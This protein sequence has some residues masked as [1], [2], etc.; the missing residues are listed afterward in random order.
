MFGSAGGGVDVQEENQQDL[1]TTYQQPR[2]V[3]TGMGVVSPIGIG[4]DLFWE[5]LRAGK[6]GIDRIESF[7][8]SPFT[9]QIAGEVKDFQAED[10]MDKKLVK[11]SDRV[12][13]FALAAS[14]L[15]VE[16]AKLK[17][18]SCDRERIGV[19]IGTGIGGMSSWEEQHSNL[20]TKGPRRISPFFIPMMIPNMP[21]GQVS[22]SLGLQG[23]TFSVVSACA[24]GGNCIGSAMDA[25]RTGQADVMLAGGSEAAVTPLG[26]GGFCAMRAMSTRNDEP[27]KASRPFDKGRDGFVMG[28]GAGIL[29]LESLE[30]AQARGAHIIAELLGYA[31]TGDAYHMTNPDPEGSGAARAMNLALKSCGKQP[32]DVDYINAHGTSTPVGDPCEIRA[33]RTV[34]GEHAEKLAI[35]SSKSM[36]G[37]TLGA[38][39]AIESVVCAL[40]LENQIIPP[41]INLEELDP[42]CALDMVPNVARKQVVNFAL[43]N[44]FGFGGHNVVLGLSR[45]SDNG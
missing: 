44:T 16:H 37:H 14:N 11:R 39:G 15:A 20:L 38:A 33:C 1:M 35:S 4:V 9:T 30:H 29:V 19:V 42:E 6:S 25:I 28:E 12:I 21:S 13:H 43:N 3:I 36:T 34:F 2:V 45:W 10:Y 5:S 23:P 41:T 40:A 32:T 8:V 26:I 22:I 31:C 7:D 17:L 24:T 27:Q 18:D